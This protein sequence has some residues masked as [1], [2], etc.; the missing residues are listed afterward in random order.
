MSRFQI[1]SVLILAMAWAVTV[2]AQQV[3]VHTQPMQTVQT[4]SYTEYVPQTRTT[5]KAVWNCDHYTV[6]PST[7]TDYQA[8]QRTTT[9]YGPVQHVPTAVSVIQP[10]V[11]TVSVP[12]KAV[13]VIPTVSVPVVPVVPAVPVAV[14]ARPVRRI[15]H[16][17]LTF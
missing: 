10:V 12:V 5:Y 3:I 16:R 11:S 1:T 7:T 15:L 4:S 6:L 17:A 9:Q 13:P 14:P 8:V 2:D